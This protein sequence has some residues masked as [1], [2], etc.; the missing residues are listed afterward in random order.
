MSSAH[1]FTL[2]CQ[3]FPPCEILMTIS[4][5]SDGAGYEWGHL[6]C[7]FTAGLVATSQLGTWLTY[8]HRLQ[9]FKAV[10]VIPFSFSQHNGHVQCLQCGILTV[11]CIIV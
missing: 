9:G 5:G 7:C 6:S 8:F 4:I 10:A 2:T 1:F 3:V 11:Y